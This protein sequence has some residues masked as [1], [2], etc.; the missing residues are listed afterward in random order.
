MPTF[1][2][3]APDG[4]EYEVTGPEGSTAEQAL[5]K[6][7]EKVGGSLQS[8][9][10]RA[11][12]E[13][14]ARGPEYNAAKEPGNLF[15]IQTSPNVANSLGGV[16][17]GIKNVFRNIGNLAGVVSDDQMRDYA[18]ND[19]ALLDTK[20]GSIGNM[21]GEAAAI[22]PFTLGIGGALGA[23][24]RFLANPVTRG[25]AEGAFQ[26]FL[27]SGPDNRGTGALIGGV[28]GAAIPAAMKGGGK[29]VRG[30][31]R[32]PE[33]QR[34]LDEGVSLTPGQM[35]PKGMFNKIEQGMQSLPVVGD[36]IEN[37]RTGAQE[38]WQN[39]IIQK[40]APGPVP[41]G[42]TVADTLDNAYQAFDPLYSQAKGFPA[43]PAINSIAGPLPLDQAVSQAVQNPAV[44]ADDAVRAKVEKFVANQL[45]AMK[46]GTSDELLSIRS[47]IRKAMRSVADPAEK[48]LLGETERALTQAIDS[49]LPQ[50]AAQA[51][52]AA[53]SKYGLYKIAEN[54]I[55]K[56]KDRA[57]G[58]TPNMLS[59][60]IKEAT[61]KGAYARGGG[62]LRDMAAAG[63][64][65]FQ[66]RN[67]PTG[68][69]LGV[70]SSLAGLI[71]ADPT[72]GTAVSGGLLGLAGT[73]VGRNLAA[74]KTVPQ[75]VMQQQIAKLFPGLS[76]AERKILEKTLKGNIELALRDT[77][78]TAL[79]GLL[80][81]EATN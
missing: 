69:R 41:I 60:A 16:G 11:I 40:A 26:G 73:Q 52:R 53:D 76:D 45:T 22:T 74:G 68:A 75:K 42:A 10:Q 2:V 25:A 44:Y 23:G 20:A 61:D 38:Q 1:V 13:A 14:R 30:L 51:L 62:R 36:V 39:A 19:Q 77:S 43:Q 4:K 34:L 59:Q 71:Y 24:G 5:A 56:A 6:V 81:S 54:A 49:Q 64:E 37:A 3:T 31:K 55:G 46:Q 58:F 47:N 48:E 17:R 27:T 7:Q 32:T 70:M 78:P 63:S 66:T 28:T 33:A 35:N 12:A 15:G 65:V 50:A 29:L 57:E 67:P 18:Q 21:I 8:K 72:V 79:R 80:V 9:V